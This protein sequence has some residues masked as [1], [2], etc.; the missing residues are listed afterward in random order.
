MAS[1]STRT[2][3]AV[4]PT[5]VALRAVASMGEREGERAP[6][7][8]RGA[9]FPPVLR[10]CARLGQTRAVPRRGEIPSA[11]AARSRKRCAC[12]PKAKIRSSLDRR[13]TPKLHS[14]ARHMG[15]RRVRRSY[16]PYV[17]TYGMF[18][19]AAFPTYRG[20]VSGRRS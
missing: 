20:G 6:C 16:R 17:A 3:W 7:R 19:H 13:G 1:T 18:D 8:E 11:G 14:A 9:F 12:S 4:S 15:A 2:G 10:D 5:R